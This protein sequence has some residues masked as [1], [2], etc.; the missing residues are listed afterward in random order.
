MKK[1]EIKTELDQLRY[2][3]DCLSVKIHDW[4]KKGKDFSEL[5]SQMRNIKSRIVIEMTKKTQTQEKP[6]KKAEKPK[7]IVTKTWP[8]LTYKQAE[9]Q[10]QKWLE[11]NDYE[12]G[13][14]FRHSINFFIKD[15][16]IS[17]DK[18]NKEIKLDFQLQFITQSRKVV[19]DI[20]W[21]VP[22]GQW[23]RLGDRLENLEQVILKKTSDPDRHDQVFGYNKFQKVLFFQKGYDKNG[24]IIKK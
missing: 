18:K 9:K 16:K 3:R 11:N 4:R 19:K 24:W 8:D 5:E 20:S 17:Q 21:G 10:L 14:C 13:Y 23:S 2:D 15:L 12:D 7:P 22:Y 1:S 6:I